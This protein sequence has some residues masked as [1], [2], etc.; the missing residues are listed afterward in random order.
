MAQKTE[1]LNVAKIEYFNVAHVSKH[2]NS[3]HLVRH[4]GLQD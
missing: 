3:Q 1:H 2:L 4:T